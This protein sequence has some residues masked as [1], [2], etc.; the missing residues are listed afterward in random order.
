[1]KNQPDNFQLV[2]TTLPGLEDMLAAELLTLGA[3]KIEPGVRNVQFMGDM[4]FMYKANFGLRTAIRILK[5]IA[6][7][8][9]RNEKELYKKLYDIDWKEYIGEGQTIAVGAAVNSENFKNSHYIELLVKDAVVDRLRDDTE[10]RPDVDR[11]NP[12][13]K[14]HIHTNREVVNVS[15]DS[16]GVP[17]FKRG[18]KTEAVKAPLSEVL[19]A[20]LLMLA[21]WTGQSH[22]VDPMCGSG[23]ILV[24]AALIAM[25]IP[26]QIRR[27]SFAFMNWKD[28]DEALFNQI[29]EGLMKRVKEFDYSITGY[30][31]N[32]GAIKASKA[33]VKSAMLEDYVKI[34]QKDFFN[35]HKPNGPT[36]IVFNPPYGERLELST[37]DFYKKIGDTFKKSYPGTTA[38]MLTGDLEGLK[39]VG[40][41]TS[42]R[43]AIK[44]T[45]YECKFVRYDMY[46]GTKKLHKLDPN[47]V[48]PSKDT[49]VEERNS[50]I[51]AKSYFS[52][53]AKES[54]RPS[55]AKATEGEAHNAKSSDEH[56]E[57]GVD[58]A[59]D[60]DIDK[61]IEKKPEPKPGSLLSRMTRRQENED[62]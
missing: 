24:E 26:P 15:L 51:D 55:Y 8:K 43:I 48:K 36:T 29:K 34:Y 23:T 54:D 6:T 14:I 35:S 44:N 40:L 13:I 5:P 62:D 21:G 46:E 58:V 16:S 60:K 32:Y 4:G 57:S 17:L 28:Y 61:P 20:G 56:C 10:K 7:F 25:N 52:K 38:W 59:K 37:E 11:E 39:K 53:A 31:M 27:S 22:F 30:D 18:Y 33:N 19:A 9:V 2:A 1:M 12:N 49:D 41:R 50:K 3:Q 47:Y 45:T 42:R